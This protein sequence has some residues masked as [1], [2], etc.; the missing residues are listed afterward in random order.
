MIEQRQLDYMMGLLELRRRIAMAMAKSWPTSAEFQAAL[1]TLM[2][3]WGGQT[4]VADDA[5]ALWV[6]LGY[7]EGM[8]FGTPAPTIRAMP[9]TATRAE[10]EKQMQGPANL[11]NWGALIVDVLQLLPSI[12]KDLTGK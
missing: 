11:V 4:A 12:I 8:Y 5:N 3:I 7:A 9:R 6:V 10:M 2:A 1:P